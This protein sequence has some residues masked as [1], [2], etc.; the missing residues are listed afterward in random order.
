[1]LIIIISKTH[2]WHLGKTRVTQLLQQYPLLQLQVTLH[3]RN[4]KIYM[5]L[6][7]SGGRRVLHTGTAALTGEHY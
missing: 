1:M 3:N 7:C 4:R 6:A 5:H 2:R